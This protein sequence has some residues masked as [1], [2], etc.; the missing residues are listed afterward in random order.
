MSLFSRNKRRM[1]KKERK[2][3]DS[4]SSACYM[5][6]CICSGVFVCERDREN[7][8]TISF[9]FKNKLFI[10][11]NWRLI[12]LQYCAGFCHTSTWI[13][14][15]CTCPPILNPPPISLP[16]PSLWVVPVHRALSTLFQLSNSHFD[17]LFRKGYTRDSNLLM[18]SRIWLEPEAADALHCS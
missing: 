5:C 15:G 17:H 18:S 4:E 7:T 10:Y 6:E 8:W 9:L 12:N 11:F 1:G 2:L 13:S 14:H 16:T 3:G